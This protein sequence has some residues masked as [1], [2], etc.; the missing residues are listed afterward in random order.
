M[1]DLEDLWNDLPTIPPPTARILAQGRRGTRPL[2]GVRR[3]LVSLGALTA[4]GGAFLAGTIV[5]SPPSPPDAGPVP[6]GQA[7]LPSPVSF[8]ADL[9]PAPSCQDLLATY[10]DRALGLVGPY[11]WDYYANAYGY[12][13]WSNG[14][15]R[16]Q[17]A[18]LDTRDTAAMKG[19]M[20]W[21]NLSDGLTTNRVTSS[22]TGTNVQ[23]QYVD[24]PDSVKTDGTNL[25]R[26]REDELITY[27]VTGPE[28]T[29]LSRL[30]LKGIDGGQ[31]LLSG[32][33][34]VVLGSDRQSSR[35]DDTGQRRG[36]RVQ[37]VDLTDPAAPTVTHDVT[38]GAATGSARQHGQTIRLVLST[39]LPD[40]DFIRP[41]KGV[42]QKEARIANRAVVKKSRLADWLPSY[43]GGQGDKQLLD[44]ANVAV[45]SA[46][47]GLD[48]AAVVTFPVADPT[49][50]QAFGL[51]GATTMAYESADHLYLASTPSFGWGCC[52]NRVAGGGDGGTSY[53]FQFDL[54]DDRAVHVASGEVEGTIRDRWS[55]DEA[56]G[57]LRVVVGPSSE[58]GDFSS[59]VT[60]RRDGAKLVEDGRLDGLGRNQE[61]KSVRWEDDLAIVVTYRQIDPLYVIDL[62]AKPKV[63]SELHV[64]GF[65][66]Y[67]HPLGSHRL[68]GVGSGRVKGA[69]WGAQMGL[70]AVQDLTSV[71]RL[72][73]THYGRN[74]EAQAA[75]D[76]RSFTWLPGYRTVL[77]VIRHGRTGWLSIQKL[78]QN[79][80]SNRMVKVEYG[81]DIDQVRTI[82]L[83]DGKVALVT[84]EDVRYLALKFRE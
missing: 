67:L 9:A 79:Q 78:D 38:Y 84:G 71:R 20:P 27:D 32:T 25:I 37:T 50:P 23:E 81:D 57:Q 73:L 69:G 8:G 60:F 44:C 83:P 58:T 15:V 6:P 24:E 35:N 26:L 22:A 4:L 63:L 77:T 42:S 14:L 28:V 39:G 7:A 17:R 36:T 76:P 3:P 21:Q 62:R 74:T 70:F 33:T 29:E 30:Q 72:D 56:G 48:T 41:R 10:V 65:S 13:P 18:S 82:G 2:R 49:A 53:L 46:K 5:A 19:R 80:L 75:W 11:G 31:I 1:T 12:G 47:V 51:A 45:P 66:S 59:L 54:T 34:V 55:I 43:D 40:L 16:F 64:S 61:V 52:F 68:I